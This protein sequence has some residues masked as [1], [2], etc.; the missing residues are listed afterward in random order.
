MVFFLLCERD[1]CTLLN[2]AQEPPVGGN[3]HERELM[4]E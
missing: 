4:F 3:N 1:L 2:D